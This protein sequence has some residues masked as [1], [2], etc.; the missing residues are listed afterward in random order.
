MRAQWQELHHQMSSL[1]HR[2]SSERLFA[3]IRQRHPVLASFPS[4]AEIIVG[5]QC[6]G[7]CPFQRN[8]VLRSL[9]SEAQAKAATSELAGQIII[10]TLWPGLDAVYGHLCRDFRPDFDDICAE[11]FGQ[12][13]LE[14]QELDLT[15]VNRI[16]ATLLMNVKRDIRRSLIHHR[17]RQKNEVC[18]DDEAV[19][20]LLVSPGK[21]DDSVSAA[22]WRKLLSPVIGRDTDLVLRIIIL[23]ETQAEAGRALGLSHAA[24]RKRHQRAMEKLQAVRLSHTAVS[25]S[26]VAVGF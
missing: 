23:G 22:E 17:V 19:H 8:L 9:I 24:A 12:I 3:T 25:H 26:G 18:C 21:D 15:A 20:H 2:K 5:Q 16:A 4:I 13:G 11:L 6:A 14:I 1:I 10:L 7:G